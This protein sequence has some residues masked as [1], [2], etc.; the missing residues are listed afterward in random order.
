MVRRYLVD[1]IDVA[2][3]E[4]VVHCDGGAR[5]GG[6]A[7][8]GEEGSESVGPKVSGEEEDGFG[9]IPHETAQLATLQCPLPIGRLGLGLLEVGR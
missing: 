7:G 9:I 2:L 8:G 1:L 6:V 3:V 5:G 4:V